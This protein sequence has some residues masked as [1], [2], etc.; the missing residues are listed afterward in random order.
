MKTRYG[1]ICSLYII[2]IN[3]SYMWLVCISVVSLCT[4]APQGHPQRPRGQADIGAEGN[5]PKQ[6]PKKWREERGYPRGGGRL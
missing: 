1:G 6:A 4:D 2:V 5:E 3:I